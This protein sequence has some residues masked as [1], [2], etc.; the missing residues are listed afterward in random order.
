MRSHPLRQ[1][2]CGTPTSYRYQPIGG[3]DNK[4]WSSC[5]QDQ[6]KEPQISL[7]TSP[8]GLVAFY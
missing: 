1:R 3:R 6:G 2:W 7:A 4:A 8:R 5:F